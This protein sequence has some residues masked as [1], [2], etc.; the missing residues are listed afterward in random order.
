MQSLCML[1]QLSSP[2]SKGKLLGTK[3]AQHTYTQDSNEAVAHVDAYKNP[4]TQGYKQ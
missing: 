4:N 3:A 2:M 1:D